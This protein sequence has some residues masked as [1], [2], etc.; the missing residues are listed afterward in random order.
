M[1]EIISGPALFWIGGD[2]DRRIQT[3][4][5]LSAVRKSGD[6]YINL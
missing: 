6:I 5:S 4:Q 2:S 3:K 1:S